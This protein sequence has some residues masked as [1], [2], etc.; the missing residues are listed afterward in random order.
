MFICL[1]DWLCL[2]S[3]QWVMMDTGKIVWVWHLVICHSIALFGVLL[4]SKFSHLIWTGA[5]SRMIFL[6]ESSSFSWQVFTSLNSC[7]SRT[8]VKRMSLLLCSGAVKCVWLCPVKALLWGFGGS[9]SPWDWKKEVLSALYETLI[10]YWF[11][12]Q[13]W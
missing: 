9:V 10:L 13:H 6:R 8:Q 5:N 12:Y 1:A 7:I 2:C 3:L 4:L 11:W